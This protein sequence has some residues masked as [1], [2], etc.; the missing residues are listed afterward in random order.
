MKETP[1]SLDASLCVQ[2][3]RLRQ[4][5]WVELNHGSESWTFQVDF[6]NASRVRLKWAGRKLEYSQAH[7]SFNLNKINTGKLV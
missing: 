3:G 1:W 2:S 5:A 4:C 7:E 6:F